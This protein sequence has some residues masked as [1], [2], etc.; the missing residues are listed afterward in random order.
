M[1]VISGH[2][3]EFQGGGKGMKKGSGGKGFQQAQD[4]RRR[5]WEAFQNYLELRCSK[6]TIDIVIGKSSVQNWD[7]KRRAFNS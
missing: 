6:R 3:T 5:H 1:A 2:Q 7:L 4:E